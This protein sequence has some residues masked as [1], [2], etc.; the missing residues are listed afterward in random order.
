MRRRVGFFTAPVRFFR[1]YINF[2]DN[3][4]RAEYWWVALWQVLLASAWWLWV[5]LGIAGGL[6]GDRTIRQALQAKHGP[7][8]VALIFGGIMLVPAVSLHVRRYHD[9]G[10]AALWLIVTILLPVL[11]LGVELATGIAWLMVPALMCV[12]GNLWCAA[13]PTRGLRF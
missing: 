4:T 3:S 12:L 8:L 7:L 1:N 11:L 2:T 13:R 5:R 6:T 9:A 10:I